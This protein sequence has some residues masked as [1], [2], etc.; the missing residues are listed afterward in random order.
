MNESEFENLK[1]AYG[2]F[3]K[4]VSVMNIPIEPINGYTVANAVD[5]VLWYYGTYKTLE[6]AYEVARSLGAGVVLN[7]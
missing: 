4:S 6:R 5:G 3:K 2:S 1:K 7:G